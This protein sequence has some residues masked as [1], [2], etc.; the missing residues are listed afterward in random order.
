MRYTGCVVK[1]SV[2][3]F[4]ALHD[5]VGQREVDLDLVDGATIGD[6][7]DQLAGRYPAVVPFM[8]TLVCAVNEEYVTSEHRLSPGDQVA[9][10]PPVRGSGRRDTGGPV[11]SHRGAAGPALVELVRRDE[12]GAVA[13]FYGVV[14]NNSRGRRVLYLEYDA[15][16][17]MAVKKMRQVA[18]EV[19]SRW[20]IT[21][22]AISH[23]IGRLEVGETSLL[24]AVSAPH[25]RE[26]FEACHHAVDRIKEIVP[27]WKKEVW[28]GGETWV[29]GHPVGAEPA[30]APGSAREALPEG[31]G[32]PKK[33]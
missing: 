27:V 28:E 4:A 14:R 26:A 13:L 16:P 23:R 18:A 21:D 29:E 7:R 19:R 15:Y 20:E 22:V 32:L 17:S 12:A 5:L 1:V 2:R 25:R 30:S 11:P 33:K 8:S 24:V 31:A 10:I 9:L 3:L 6:L